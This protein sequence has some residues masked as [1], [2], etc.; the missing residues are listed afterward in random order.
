[1]QLATVKVI[2]VKVGSHYVF[3]AEYLKTLMA[4]GAVNIW[5]TLSFSRR[6]KALQP[7]LKN[8]AMS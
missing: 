8:Y 6:K 7:R 2:T 1:M 4:V 3:D 5:Y